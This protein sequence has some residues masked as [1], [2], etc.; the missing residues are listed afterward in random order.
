M[1]RERRIEEVSD[2]ISEV[3]SA[4]AE[5]GLRYVSDTSPGYRRKR[6]GT[7]FTYYDKDGKR[8]TDKAVIRR[9]KSIGIPR[10][11][12]LSGSV[13]RPTDTFRRRDWMRAGGS[14]TATIPNGAN[15]ET[16]TSTSTLCS[17]PRRCLLCAPASRPI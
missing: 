10:P 1:L 16:R 12:S 14:S 17:S 7:S 2:H 4:I 6:T 13:P 3:A 8:I 11:T 9:I 15:Y 5:E